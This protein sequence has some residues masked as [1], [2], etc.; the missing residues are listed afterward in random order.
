MLFI[1]ETAISR[2]FCRD[3]RASGGHQDPPSLPAC[4]ASA[5]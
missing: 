2:I 4:A 3:R 5:I 1:G